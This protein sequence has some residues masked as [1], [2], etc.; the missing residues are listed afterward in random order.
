MVR[1]SSLL[2][3]TENVV[4]VSVCGDEEKQSSKCRFLS[5]T[6]LVEDYC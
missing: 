4:V 5:N 1:A 3:V 6:L 2:F